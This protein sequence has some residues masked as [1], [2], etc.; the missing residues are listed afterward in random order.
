MLNPVFLINLVAFVHILP[1]SILAE[2][3]TFWIIILA[4]G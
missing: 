2:V 1:Q 3:K 4:P